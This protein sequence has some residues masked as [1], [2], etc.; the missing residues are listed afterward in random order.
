[1]IHG[2][3]VF[4]M[5]IGLVELY[6]VSLELCLSTFPLLTSLFHVLR[7]LV[8]F[9]SFDGAL[10]CLARLW[11]IV[12]VV[13]L[14]HVLLQLIVLCSLFCFDAYKLESTSSASFS[15]TGEPLRQLHGPHDRSNISCVLP[16]GH[17]ASNG[18]Q[19][20]LH[21]W[22]PTDLCGGVKRRSFHDAMTAFGFKVAWL[23]TRV[24]PALST[25]RDCPVTKFLGTVHL[26]PV[27]PGE[28]PTR[29]PVQLP[30]CDAATHGV[31]LN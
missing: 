10:F 17:E 27:V 2:A 14:L 3:H 18:A 11:L 12:H 24:S 23:A 20:W 22:L 29:A 1:M 15:K 13:V 8:C 7:W 4:Y 25:S 28:R 16:V 5:L 26:L 19:T 21:A 6:H 9:V 30:C 31:H